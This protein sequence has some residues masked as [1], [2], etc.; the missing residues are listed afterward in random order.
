MTDAVRKE[1]ESLRPDETVYLLAVSHPEARSRLI[2]GHSWQAKT[3]ETGIVHLRAA[4][5]VQILDEN[6]RS[7]REPDTLQTNGS[8]QRPRIRRLLV[9]LD[10]QA[11]VADARAKEAGKKDVY[12]SINLIIRRHQRENNFN[13]ILQ[14]IKSLTL[15]DAVL[16]S[17]LQE[18]YLGFGDPASAS[19]DRL[20]NRLKTIDF[21]DTFIDWQ[22]VID[23]FLTTVGAE[24]SALGLAY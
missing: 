12:D 21:R 4:E 6:G 22:H 24:T 11:F 20:T 3:R 14:T 19:F 7:I 16:P 1:W 10:A 15:S 18:V 23:S 9:N 8:L 13:K 5:I 2:N 17:W